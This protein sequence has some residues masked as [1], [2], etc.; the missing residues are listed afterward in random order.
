MFGDGYVN[1]SHTLL[2]MWLLI[3]AW[4]KKDQWKNFYSRYSMSKKG[5]WNMRYIIDNNK[6]GFY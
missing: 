6:D 1:S 5:I 3:H 4:I 2:A